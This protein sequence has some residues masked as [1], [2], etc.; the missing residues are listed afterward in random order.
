M[1][2][3]KYLVLSSLY[4]F[5]VSAHA[6]KC[7][8]E[9]NLWMGFE[10]AKSFIQNQKITT[11]TEF[12]KW[13]RSEQRPKN[14]PSTPSRSYKDKWK[15]WND[16]LGTKKS[17]M[18][19]QEAKAFIQ[20]Q[21]ITTIVEFRKWSKSEQRPKNFP[22]SPHRTYSEEWKGWN[23]FL[24][25]EK[26]WMNFQEAKAFIQKRGFTSMRQFQKWSISEQRPENFPSAPNQTYKDEW[27]SWGDFLGTGNISNSKR[28]WM[29]FQEAKA[30]IQTQGIT[31]MAEFRKWSKSD[32]R[33]ENFPSA[34]DQTYKDE[35]TSWGDFLGTGNISTKKIDRTPI[36]FKKRKQIDNKWEN[37]PINSDQTDSIQSSDTKQNS[38]TKERQNSFDEIKNFLKQEIQ[39]KI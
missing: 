9:F 32:Q 22:S 1:L 34:P 19:F 2:K 11:S 24:G 38:D 35:W 26:S 7:E 6:L 27:I 15:G 21:G 25:T 28:E 20:T 36:K 29:H 14:F 18:H 33:P 23:D 37:I 5:S 30:F 39:K 13:S 31:T 16:F 4:V 17:W 8:N 3:L 10:E 12:G